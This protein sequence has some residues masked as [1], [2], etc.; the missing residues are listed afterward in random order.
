[1]PCYN[2]FWFLWLRRQPNERKRTYC[3]LSL[4]NELYTGCHQD[5]IQF[6]AGLLTT[7]KLRVRSRHRSK[8]RAT[9]LSVACWSSSTR[10]SW[11][12]VDS[13]LFPHWPE[14]GSKTLTLEQAIGE[15]AINQTKAIKSCLICTTVSLVW[16][17]IYLLESGRSSVDDESI[18]CVRA[19]CVV[20]VWADDHIG[21]GLGWS[22]VT[23]TK[24]TR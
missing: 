13:H 16:T 9:C 17:W 3:P 23:G 7:S 24:K 8:C 21:H 15:T 1:M 14:G 2:N 18:T 22:A 6:S 4:L 10:A 11:Q 5:V 12:S 19:H 20:P